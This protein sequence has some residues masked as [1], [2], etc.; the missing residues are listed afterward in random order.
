MKILYVAPHLSTGGLPQYLWKK[1]DEFKKNHEIFV[2]EY[3]NLSNEYVVQ[4][5]KIKSLLPEENFFTLGEDKFELL[6][7][8][9]KVNPQ[10]VHVE[11]A[12][13]LF[14]DRSL[15]K[16]LYG[17]KPRKFSLVTTSH[18]SQVNPEELTYIPDKFV[19]VSEWSRKQFQDRLKVEVP[20]D[21]WEYPVENLRKISKNEAQKALGIF[22]PEHKHVLN[23]G[24]FTHGKNQKE[25]FELAKKVTDKNIRFHFVGN[26]AVNFKEAWEPLMKDCPSN[27]FV[28]GER[29]DAELFYE[30]ADVFYFSSLLELN[31]LVVKEALSYQLPVLMRKLPTYLNSYDNNPLVEYINEDE[32][33]NLKKLFKI[34]KKKD[35]YQDILTNPANVLE[36]KDAFLVDFNNGAE[37]TILG[38]STKEYD[39]RF[40]DEDKLVYSSAIKCNNWSRPSRKYVA[41][42]RVE[43]SHKEEL[44]FSHNFDLRGKKVKITLDSK[45]LG[46]TLAWMPQIEKFRKTS[47]AQVD[48][49]YFNK[50]LKFDYPEIKFVSPND[51]EK[52]YASYKLGYYSGKDRFH[53]TP[54]D[55][56]DVPLCKMAS[57]ILGIDYEETIPKL[58]LPTSER[59]IKG[60]Y[61]C[62][63][64]ASTAGC[65]LWQR[66]NAWQ[67]VIDYLNSKGFMPVLI[68]KESWS[69]KNI[70]NKSGDVPLDDRITDLL[71]CEFFIGLGSGLSWLSWALNKKTILISGFSKPYAEFEQNCTRIINENVCNGCWNDKTVAF[72]KGDWNWCPRQKGTDRHFE[73]SKEITEEMVY[74]AID[75]LV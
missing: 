47:G 65:K 37:L 11:E 70:L 6:E 36:K 20:L 4:K 59:K 8:I 50:S 29:N 19:L 14:M 61:V 28:W 74:A 34:L 69:F 71:H 5:D 27:C 52:Y 49:L 51:G 32:E 53:H 24:L 75:K 54:S 66:P 68:Q 35:I 9:K 3:E 45:S 31:P 7:I 63:T 17:D 12:P 38:E 16:R 1:I 67:N 18:S 72:D 62:F 48:C 40:Y 57:D 2:I 56:R 64:T 44:V 21:T 13:E 58:V 55:P 15:A 26:Q 73:C 25:I 33:A 42:W 60:K 22:H 41:N 39:V 43:A 23:V 10:I 30:A 46:D